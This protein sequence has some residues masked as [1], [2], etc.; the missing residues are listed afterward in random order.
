[1]ATIAKEAN[2]ARTTVS[3]VLNGHG[4]ARN[5]SENTIKRV[6]EIARRLQYV[7]NNMALNL[8]RRRSGLIGVML[9]GLGTEWVAQT[10]HGLQDTLYAQTPAYHPLLTAHYSDREI[11]R[12]EMQFFLGSRVEGL[13]IWGGI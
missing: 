3:Y 1:M 13:P 4:R 7:P 2:V 5:I 9:T 6:E 10:M 8:R 11:E 12:R